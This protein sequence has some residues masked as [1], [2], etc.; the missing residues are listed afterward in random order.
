MAKKLELYRDWA[1]RFTDYENLVI[2]DAFDVLFYGTIDEVVSKIPT[3]NV[4]LAAE[5]NCYPDPT[6]ASR[7]T[8]DTPWRYVNGGLTAGT[9]ARILEWMDALESCP[10]YHPQALDQQVLNMLRADNS[11]LTPIDSH[12]EL[13]YCAF[14]DE[15]EL[16]AENGMPLNKLCGTHPNFIHFNGGAD[17]AGWFAAREASLQ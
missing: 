12:T 17:N 15:G 9:P 6:I 5:R 13:F 7:C 10:Y 1:A 2:S 3:D 16:G 4:L 8:G 14:I 11:P